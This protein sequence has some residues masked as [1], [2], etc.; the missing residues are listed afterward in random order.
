MGFLCDSRTICCSC[1]ECEA[2][3]SQWQKLAD[4]WNNDEVSETKVAKVD[5]TNRYE[6]MCWGKNII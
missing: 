1:P 2:L 4:N 6:D 3:S 5:C